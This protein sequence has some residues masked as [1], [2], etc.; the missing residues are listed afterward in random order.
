MLISPRFTPAAP[1]AAL[2]AERR[3]IIHTAFP[4]DDFMAGCLMGIPE[5][6][7]LAR[8]GKRVLDKT[9]EGIFELYRLDERCGECGGNLVASQISFRSLRAE[10][11]CRDC[12]EGETAGRSSGE[13]ELTP[14][15][16]KRMTKLEEKPVGRR[17]P[18][19]TQDGTGILDLYTRRSI[20]AQALIF[21][22]ISKE[23]DESV[24]RWLALCFLESVLY[25]RAFRTGRKHSLIR[26]ESNPWFDFSRSLERRQ[27]DL[28][29][30]GGERFYFLEQGS[31]NEVLEG[32]ATLAWTR[33]LGDVP[34]GAAD[35]SVAMVP[36]DGLL[37]AP[38]E[39]QIC[40]A[41]LNLSGESGGSG[42]CGEPTASFESLKSRCMK[43]SRLNII[44]GREL[45]LPGFAIRLDHLLGGIG[46]ELEKTL[47]EIDL[48]E[49]A[50]MRRFYSPSVLV[51]RES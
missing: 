1:L 51:Y 7:E 4:L 43:G 11:V 20:H 32:T 40:A 5:R 16:L 17:H 13:H 28:Q 48:H 42:E 21:E 46:L 25:F 12:D 24:R 50:N 47:P 35:C 31:I 15:E 45:A 2:S 34:E 22:A 27:R 19:E 9:G 33:E 6:R 44:V 14:G 36:Y 3:V 26:T 39:D 30:L 10:A 8:A 29:V 38:L 37:A 49:S 23:K 18:E 41:W